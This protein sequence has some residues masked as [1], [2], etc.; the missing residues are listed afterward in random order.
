MLKPS[1]LNVFS[2]F[3]VSKCNNLALANGSEN[4]K[5]VTHYH[6]GGWRS[7]SMVRGRRQYFKLNGPSD[8]GSIDVNSITEFLD[9][10]GL[11][12]QKRETF[13]ESDGGG[14]GG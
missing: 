10:F 1:I 13:H 14:G 9:G 8:Y 6:N 3:N 7:I 2:R 4:M 5:L 12:S 11:E